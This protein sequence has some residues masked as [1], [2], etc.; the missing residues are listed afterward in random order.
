MIY[1]AVSLFQGSY[2]DIILESGAYHSDILPQARYSTVLLRD[3]N[4]GC[5]DL[6][7][8]SNNAYIKTYPLKGGEC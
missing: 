3:A 2:L 5:D 6:Q 1:H 7:P 8:T 4:V